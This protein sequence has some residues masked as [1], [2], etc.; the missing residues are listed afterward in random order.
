M[1]QNVFLE[2]TLWE[3]LV[4]VQVMVRRGVLLVTCQRPI[5]YFASHANES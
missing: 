4:T 1:K 3:V 5:Q 2:G